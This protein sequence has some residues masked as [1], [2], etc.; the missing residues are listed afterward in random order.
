MTF[1]DPSGICRAQA[2]GPSGILNQ[3]LLFHESL[4]GFYG[5]YDVTLETVFGINPALSSEYITF[6]LEDNIFTGGAS[7][8]G[9]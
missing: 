5:K 1:F 4:H 2:S 9:N 3:A 7:T 8:C 6:Y